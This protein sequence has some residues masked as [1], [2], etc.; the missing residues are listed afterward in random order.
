MAVETFQRNLVCTLFDTI[1]GF[2]NGYRSRVAFQLELGTDSKGFFC[3][4]F[5]QSGSILQNL[6]Q[7]TRV[8]HDLLLSH[9]THGVHQMDG[10]PMGKDI[11]FA[12]Q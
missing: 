7:H 1:Y 5:L 3:Q 8:F 4:D 2:A 9:R 12:S 10:T 6:W 11:Q